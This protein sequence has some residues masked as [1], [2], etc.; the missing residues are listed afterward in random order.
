MRIF[1]DDRAVTQNFDSSLEIQSGGFYRLSLTCAELLACMKS[2]FMHT[3]WEN[4]QRDL[5]TIPLTLIHG[6]FHA[7]NS[8]WMKDASQ[9]IRFFDWENVG[10]GSGPQE[11]G[12]YFLTSV[13]PREF[14]KESQ[15]KLLRSY[16]EELIKSNPQVAAHMDFDTC[17]NE[18]VYA[19]LQW[20]CCFFPVLLAI[21]PAMYD[22]F[23]DRYNFFI[24]DHCVDLTKIGPHRY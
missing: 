22:Y 23:H 15:K 17:W 7:S 18:F 11:L 21:A 3:S 14:G 20:S 13:D 19:G 9:K 5:R 16:H 6:D 2:V 1:L 8:M 12:Y 10:W 24:K 4:F